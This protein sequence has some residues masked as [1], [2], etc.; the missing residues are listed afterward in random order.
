V[1]RQRV[2]AHGTLGAIVFQP[3]FYGVLKECVAAR[4]HEHGVA[5]RKLGLRDGAALVS[6]TIVAMQNNGR[7]QQFPHGIRL[8]HA[9]NGRS[10]VQRR[11]HDIG[12]MIICMI[13]HMNI[14]M[15]QQLDASSSAVT[16]RQQV[17]A[18]HHLF[19]GF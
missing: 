9:A 12:H 4:Q 17:Q 18:T 8:N 16:V 19:G 5:L 10:V 6:V 15:M 3:R 7:L 2:P 1:R 14:C 13:G 11:F